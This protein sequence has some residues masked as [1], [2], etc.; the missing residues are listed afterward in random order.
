MYTNV[1]SLNEISIL[2]P[3]L[4]SS[5]LN[6]DKGWSGWDWTKPQLF[7]ASAKSVLDKATPYEVSLACP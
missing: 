4:K 1:M 7:P 3:T 6:K 2:T 5:S